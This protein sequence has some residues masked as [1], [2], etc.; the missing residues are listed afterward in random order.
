VRQATAHLVAPA[1]ARIPP[2]SHPSPS[3]HPRRPKRPLVLA[4]CPWPPTARRITIQEPTYLPPISRDVSMENSPNLSTQSPDPR[5]PTA[6][7]SVSIGAHVPPS[8]HGPSQSLM[9]FGRNR[10]WHTAIR[11][12][13]GIAQPPALPASGTLYQTIPLSDVYWL[14]ATLD[15]VVA[16]SRRP[17][18]R[19]FT[20]R[21]C[22]RRA[23]AKPSNC[24]FSVWK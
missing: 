4:R 7:G 1:R 15:S 22:S 14:A 5:L 9:A 11:N 10:R 21:H 8:V 13:T 3:F 17:F 16:P 23:P 2:N 24:C 19:H 20:P 18:G 12:P 6:L